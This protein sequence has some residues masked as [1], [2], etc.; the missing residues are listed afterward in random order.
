MK[1]IHRSKKSLL[2]KYFFE[3]EQIA[4]KKDELLVLQRFWLFSIKNTKMASEK[5]VSFVTQWHNWVVSPLRDQTDCSRLQSW[6]WTTTPS[7]SS[8]LCCQS[9]EEEKP[10]AHSNQL[11]PKASGETIIC[12][13]WCNSVCSGTGTLL[14]R[15]DKHS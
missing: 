7:R 1:L 11:S 12:V 2:N 5:C 13:N 10:V 6:P 14:L 9:L 4:K 3:T 8:L 15:E